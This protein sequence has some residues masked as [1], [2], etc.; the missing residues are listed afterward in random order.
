[1]KIDKNE[2]QKVKQNF[3]QFNTTEKMNFPK[4]QLESKVC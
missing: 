2:I 1:M 4:K 3:G